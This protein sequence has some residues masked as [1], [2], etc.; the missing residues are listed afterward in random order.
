M[1][2]WRGTEKRVVSKL[3]FLHGVSSQRF[4]RTGGLR[5]CSD[6]NV[7]GDVLQR[8]Q[9]APK[10]KKKKRGKTKYIML[11]GTPTK[12]MRCLGLLL[13][14]CLISQLPNHSVSLSKLPAS[15]YSPGLA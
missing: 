3:S 10:K 2:Y 13:S 4:F 7:T 8:N 11:R 15:P 5:C 9:T 12:L 6:F 14:S 1:L